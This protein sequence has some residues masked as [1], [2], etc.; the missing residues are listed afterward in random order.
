MNSYSIIGDV[1][2]IYI[3]SKIG[4]HI[5]R[6]DLEDFNRVRMFH[7]NLSRLPP[8]PYCSASIGARIKGQGNS[9]SMHRLILSFPEGLVIDHINGD[10]LDNRK[11]NLRIVTRKQNSRNITKPSTNKLGVRG[12]QLNG[13][14]YVARIR[15]NGE[16]ICLGRYTSIEMA[17]NSYS[18]AKKLYFGDPLIELF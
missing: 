3:P 7:W 6:V 9:V 2:E 12:V 8:Y 18:N 15:V 11:A 14:K 4:E 17:S 10:T 16:E 13:G 5:S 1:V